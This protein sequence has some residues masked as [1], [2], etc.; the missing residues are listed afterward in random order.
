[1]GIKVSGD[2][3]QITDIGAF[4]RQTRY[5]MNSEGMYELYDDLKEYRR[6]DK[7]GSLFWAA[8]SV[9]FISVFDA[10]VGYVEGAC[11]QFGGREITCRMTGRDTWHGRAVTKFYV[12]GWGKSGSLTGCIDDELGRI[13]KI[14]AVAN[15]LPSPYVAQL[16]NLRVEP[17]PEA[18]FSIPLDYHE[19]G[20]P[21]H[22]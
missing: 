19:A 13:V 2:R 20:K 22:E 17:Q 18:E 5:L 12:T 9:P 8:I 15:E 21:V 4:G 1:L 3:W 16:I 10:Q 14:V 11:R 6:L 7:E